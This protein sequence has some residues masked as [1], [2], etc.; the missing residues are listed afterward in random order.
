MTQETHQ[1]WTPVVLRKSKPRI[2]I[3]RPPQNKALKN[4]ESLD[5]NAQKLL[6][7]EA[8]KQIQQ[9][10]CAM[11]LSQE[12]LANKLCVKKKVI[13]EYETGKVVPNRKIL[14]DINR[15]LKITVKN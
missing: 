14:N 5:P 2:E 10:R 7:L 9:A 4:L 15:V 1:D 13:Q 12:E 11:H 8:A 6:G 3:N